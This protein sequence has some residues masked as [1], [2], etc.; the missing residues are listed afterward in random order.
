L[1][2]NT[3]KISRSATGTQQFH[4]DAGSSHANKIYLL[5]TNSLGT[6]SANGR[7]SASFA[8][9]SRIPPALI[10]QTF[11]HAYVV[12]GKGRFDFASN[13]MPLTLTK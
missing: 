6:L 11:N 2:T 7:G 5:L 13:A 1:T 3:S 4:L 8:I 10:G 9:N 12:Q